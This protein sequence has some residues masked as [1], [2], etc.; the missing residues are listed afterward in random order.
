[1]FQYSSCACVWHSN[2]VCWRVQNSAPHGQVTGSSYV[3]CLVVFSEVAASSTSLC[4]HLYR[5]P[6]NIIVL[7]VHSY[8]EI[9][10]RPGDA[11]ISS[12]IRNVLHRDISIG[13]DYVA[14]EGVAVSVGEV[15]RDD[16]AGAGVR[17]R[18]GGH[19]GR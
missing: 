1:M 14:Q 2:T 5:A 10:D 16:G 8:A 12:T 13:L 15:W 7:V 18:G 19:R 6:T 11:R 9:S 17:S 3:I 4:H